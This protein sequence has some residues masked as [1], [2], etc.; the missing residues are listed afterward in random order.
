[1]L[2]LYT[3]L[4]TIENRLNVFYIL[5]FVPLPLI[6]YY[7]VR[8][9]SPLMFGFLLL[10]LKKDKLRAYNEALHGQKALGIIIILSNLI[11]YYA[12]FSFFPFALF[13]GGAAVTYIAYL[14]GLFLTFFDF[15]ALRKAFTP[16]F[17]VAAATSISYVS[18]WLR[19]YLSPYVIPLFTSL[20]GTIL[21]A[22]QVKTIVQYPNFLTLDTPRGSLPLLI[23][24]GCVGVYGALVF[25]ILL[26]V[27]L[28]EEP[29][30]LKTKTLWTAI[31]IIGILILN[32][33]RVVIILVIAYYYDFNVAELT[34]HPYLGYALLLTWLM[35]FLF[36]FSKRQSIS[37]KLG[38]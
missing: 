2:K 34:V 22:L 12:L 8:Y 20:I 37:E 19:H 30:S 21:N 5:A 18:T 7:D 14:L 24:W 38:L 25:S 9:F 32:V 29:A 15:S 35:L 36:L 27:M 16:I 26:I 11:V 4:H 10:L 17:I 13:Y 23:I 6:A 1:M 31:G 28:S 33:I 3:A